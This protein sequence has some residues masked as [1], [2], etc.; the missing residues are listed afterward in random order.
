MGEEY[1]DVR[2]ISL[3][4]DKE[5]YPLCFAYVHMDTKKSAERLFDELHGVKVKNVPIWVTFKSSHRSRGRV[6]GRGRGRV[7]GRGRRRGS[8]AS[9]RPSGSR[10]NGR[11][12]LEGG[13]SGKWSWKGAK[14]RKSTGSGI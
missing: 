14:K 7:R 3:P 5:G 4:K 13:S 12:K 11:K 10:F 8:S 9:V 1:G 6:R 2:G